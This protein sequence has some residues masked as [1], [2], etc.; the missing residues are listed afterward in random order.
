M[1][2]ALSRLRRVFNDPLLVREGNTT[3]LTDKA[4]ALRQRFQ[5]LVEQWLD[6]T[7]GRL[8]FD[9]LTSQRV[10]TLYAT[11]YV[12]FAL[13]PAL[14]ASLSVQAPVIRACA[15]TSRRSASSRE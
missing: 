7:L 3:R 10:F 13:L 6:V 8:D 15:N 12:Q 14:A 4:V 9:P 5:P 1:S 2:A 11:D